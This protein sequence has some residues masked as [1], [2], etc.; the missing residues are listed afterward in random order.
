MLVT[1]AF[2][3]RCPVLNE[4]GIP[5]LYGGEEVKK[6]PLSPRITVV[7]SLIV[8]VKFWIFTPESLSIV[9]RQQ[10]PIRGQRD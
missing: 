2:Q 10:N 5:F 4:L 8:C 3:W 6:F 1:M 9:N 7:L